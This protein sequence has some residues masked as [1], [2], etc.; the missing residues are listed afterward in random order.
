MADQIAI[1]MIVPRNQK[2]A[3]PKIVTEPSIQ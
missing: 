1:N 3:D 2:I